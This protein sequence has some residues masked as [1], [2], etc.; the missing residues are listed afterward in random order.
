M[1]V[2]SALTCEAKRGHLCRSA[3][4]A[5]LARGDARGACARPSASSPRSPSVS[6]ARSSRCARST[7]VVSPAPTDITSGLPRVEELFEARVP[8]GEAI[9]SEIDGVV[10]I[11]QENERR[12]VRVTNVDTLVDEYEMPAKGKAARRRTATRVVAGAAVAQGRRARRAKD[13]TRRSPRPVIARIIAASSVPSRQEQALRSS[14]KSAKS[15]STPF[16]PPP[17]CA[18]RTARWCTPA[19]SSR[20]APATRRTSCASRAARRSAVPGRRSPEGLPVP[21]CEH[22]RQA[23]RGHRAPDAA[24]GARRPPGRHRPAAAA[25]SSTASSTRR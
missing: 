22:Q 17:A 16:R 21:G 11:V 1:Y 14:T 25:T 19:S 24:Q 15:A 12:I 2:R 13:T 8:K 6:R 5:D 9:I 3:T 23:H 10:E 20:K 18:S 7:P 4:A